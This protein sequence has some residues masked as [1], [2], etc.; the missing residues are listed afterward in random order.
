MAKFQK[1]TDRQKA[2][3]EYRKLFDHPASGRPLS[4]RSK[5]QQR[6]IVAAVARSKRADA[7]YEARKRP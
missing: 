4:Q 7:Q 3:A 2:D 1:P 6:K 5:R